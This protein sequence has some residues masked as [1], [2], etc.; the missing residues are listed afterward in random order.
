MVG[1]GKKFDGD[2]WGW[3]QIHVPVQL[4]STKC[5]LLKCVQ[6]WSTAGRPKQQSVW[7]RS[8]YNV[9]IFR[10]AISSS[11]SPSSSR[12]VRKSLS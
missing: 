7:S 3:G 6:R 11:Q 2:G 10:C 9:I 8:K 5:G 12:Q 4:S 1:D